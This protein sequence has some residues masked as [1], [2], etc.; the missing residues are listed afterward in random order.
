MI[1]LD[2]KYIE[3]DGKEE[4]IRFRRSLFWDV[5]A[6]ALDMDKNRRLILERVFSRG[7]IEE[8]RSVNQYY[9]RDE[10]RDAIKLIGSLDNKTLH[11][12]SKFYQIK[13]TELKCYK[14]NQ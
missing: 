14:K 6:S 2:T 1:E 10:I 5:P 9:T 12:I 11:F 7:N 4:K 13:Y 8:F 3:V